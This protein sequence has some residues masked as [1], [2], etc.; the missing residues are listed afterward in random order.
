MSRATCHVLPVVC[1][2]SRVTC[3]VEGPSTLVGGG[4][5]PRLIQRPPAGRGSV[6]VS[7]QHGEVSPRETITVADMTMVTPN[8]TVSPSCPS[9]TFSSFSDGG[10]E[11]QLKTSEVAISL[12]SEIG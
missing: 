1:H 5:E 2:V 9:K 6:V 10:T 4:A 8:V 7:L 12:G 11:S 3:G